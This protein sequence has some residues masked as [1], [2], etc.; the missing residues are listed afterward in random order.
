VFKEALSQREKGRS[1]ALWERVGE[2]AKRFCFPMVKLLDYQDK[3]DELENSRNPFAMVVKV[4]LKGL[5][6]QKSP[7]QRFDWKVALYKALHE[8]NYSEKEIMGLFIFLDWLMTLPEDLNR[9]FDD[10]VHHYEQERRMQ[11]VTTFEEKG[12]NKVS[13]KTHAKM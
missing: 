5:E 11:Y 2:R 4:H 9:Q 3:W 13:C 6:T 12:F 10:F 8:E 7:Q 1:L